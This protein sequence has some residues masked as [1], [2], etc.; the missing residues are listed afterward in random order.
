[1]HTHEYKVDGGTI[2]FL[3][4]GMDIP[5]P[6]QIVPMM[7]NDLTSHAKKFY[8]TT[9]GIM[10]FIVAD[11]LG[12]TSKSWS[13]AFQVDGY[14]MMRVLSRDGDIVLFMSDNAEAH[15][16]EMSIPYSALR[17]FVDDMAER[18]FSSYLEGQRHSDNMMVGV[19]MYI[20][21][22]KGK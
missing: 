19:G 12:A 7:E 22:T 10:S 5:G 6:C 3:T 15:C 9:E 8:A 21:A 1:M 20:L 16:E 13:R 14:R 4:N 2:Y 17:A 18:K 11:L